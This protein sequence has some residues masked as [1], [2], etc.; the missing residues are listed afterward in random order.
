MVRLGCAFWVSCLFS[1]TKWLHLAKNTFLAET[2]ERFG[3]EVGIP[4]LPLE[5]RHTA[6]IMHDSK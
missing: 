5:D 1:A 2:G 3:R 6:N 4:G